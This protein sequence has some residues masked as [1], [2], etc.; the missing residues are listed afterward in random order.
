MN[1]SVYHFP[2]FISLL[3]SLSG[4]APQVHSQ[5]V[6]I[7]LRRIF[8]VMPN[9]IPNHRVFEIEFQTSKEG[10][11]LWVKSL[12]HLPYTGPDCRLSTTELCPHRFPG[13]ED[14]PEIQPPTII[15]DSWKMFG[16]E[17]PT[18]VLSYRERANFT[19]DLIFPEGSPIVRAT[20]KADFSLH[21]GQYRKWTIHSGTRS[22]DSVDWIDA[23]CTVYKAGE[24]DGT[25]LPVTKAKLSTK[26]E[27]CIKGEMDKKY[28]NRECQFPIEKYKD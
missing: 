13:F 21:E 20:F 4:P 25:V 23:E 17:E 22:T 10:E 24:K 15:S 11:D 6:D 28:K 2:P 1:K 16:K 9:V 8:F 14:R 26:L 7:A 19:V 18:S 27:A 5:P 3:F 12:Y